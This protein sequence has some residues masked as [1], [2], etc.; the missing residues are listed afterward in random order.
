[1]KV[2]QPFMAL[3]IILFSTAFCCD[4]C[5]DNGDNGGGGTTTEEPI[6]S[7]ARIHTRVEAGRSG[8][9]QEVTG[10]RDFF[11]NESVRVVNNGKGRINFNDGSTITLY[12]NTSTDQVTA[13]FSPAEIGVFL[14]NQGFDGYV[15]QGSKFIVN[16]PNGSQVRILGTQFFVVFDESNYYSTV[17]NFD[18]TVLFTPPG[19]SERDLPPHTMVDIAPDGGI[20][21]LELPYGPANF[22]SAADSSG[23]PVEGVRALRDEFT[24]PQPGGAPPTEPPSKPVTIVIRHL[25]MKE[26]DSYLP[27]LAESWSVDPDG[28]IVEFRLRPG[29]FL[30]NGEPFTTATVR[31]RLE[32]EWAYALEGK[33]QFEIFDDLTIRFNLS[34]P[35]AYY[36]LDQMSIFEFEVRLG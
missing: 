23:S 13:K 36:V 28:Y 7:I 29:I 5:T 34:G 12:N 18:G 25:V 19:G 24:Q 30:P 6:G 31:E 11:D 33:V 2:L 17:G 15:P 9:I 3:L 21:F 14:S 1:M 8:D 22:E 16:M 10:S 26:G 4:G 35:D 27:D 32:A 20:N